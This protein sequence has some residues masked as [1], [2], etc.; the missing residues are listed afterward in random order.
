MLM[1]I[2]KELGHLQHAY[3]W[4]ISN[5]HPCSKYLPNG[6]FSNKG[7]FDIT[8]AYAQC[9]DTGVT[10]AYAECDD[11]VSIPENEQVTTLQTCQEMAVRKNSVKQ[12]NPVICFEGGL[13]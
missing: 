6:R 5:N 2:R 8:K 11:V 9:D 1:R 10:T 4:M 13:F 12:Y 3:L 7:N